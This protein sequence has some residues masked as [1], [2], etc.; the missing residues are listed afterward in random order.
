LGD[1]VASVQLESC[2]KEHILQ[3][4]HL[5]LSN[6]E[7]LGGAATGFLTTPQVWRM[8]QEILPSNCTV[9][10]VTKNVQELHELRLPGT[11]MVQI[12]NN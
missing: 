2:C 5:G 7:V 10:L 11:I 1:T 6:G 3:Q 9:N 12:Q 8:T 4:L